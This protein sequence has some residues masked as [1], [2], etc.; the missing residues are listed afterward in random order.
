MLRARLPVGREFI[1]RK[2]DRLGTV[3]T[4]GAVTKEKGNHLDAPGKDL[5]S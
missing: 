1:H 5:W 4:P 2:H 3:W